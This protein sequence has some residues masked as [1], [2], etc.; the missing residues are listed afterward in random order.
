ML[1]TVNV[2][3]QPLPAQAGR[4]AQRSSQGKDFKS[5]FIILNFLA[6]V[7]NGGGISNFQARFSEWT[8]DGNEIDS[9]WLS[10]REGS[11]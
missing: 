11:R 2:T 5:R 10:W 3:L 9:F 1:L 6:L 7:K 8:A 4:V